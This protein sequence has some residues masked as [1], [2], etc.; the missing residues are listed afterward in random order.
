M[1]HPP[2]TW[3]LRPRPAHPSF[4]NLMLCSDYV[5]NPMDLATMEGASSAARIAVNEILERDGRP[6]ADRAHVQSDYQDAND[7][8]WLVI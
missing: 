5:Q 4:P 1:V 8:A 6:I 2:G 3:A 7:A